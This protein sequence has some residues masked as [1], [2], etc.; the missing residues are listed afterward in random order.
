MM[1]SPRWEAT[2]YSSTLDLLRAIPGQYLVNAV[3]G[4]VGDLRQHM[5]Q[6]DFGIDPVQ[7]GCADQRADGSRTF[8][9]AVS[10][11]EKVIAPAYGDV[12]RRPV[13]PR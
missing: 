4:M 3:D 8:A 2:G 5:R 10:T 11:S 7:L 1:A 12:T 13:D 9:S 6:P